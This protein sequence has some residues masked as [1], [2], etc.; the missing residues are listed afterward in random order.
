MSWLIG[1]DTG[2]VTWPDN[3]RLF[4]HQHDLREICVSICIKLGITEI[5]PM[6]GD[7]GPV[8]DSQATPLPYSIW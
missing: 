8:L 6:S 4:P 1:W 2:E 3:T 7:H 5:V